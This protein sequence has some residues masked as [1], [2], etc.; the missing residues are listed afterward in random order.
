MVLDF[1]CIVYDCESSLSLLWRLIIHIAFRVMMMKLR[2]QRIISRRW[3]TEMAITTVLTT[4]FIDYTDTRKLLRFIWDKEQEFI[5]DCTARFLWQSCT[6]RA[7]KVFIRNSLYKHAQDKYS[8]VDKTINR[9]TDISNTVTKATAATAIEQKSPSEAA[10][11][12]GLC[13]CSTTFTD[14]SLKIYLQKCFN[15]T[16]IFARIYASKL[17]TIIIHS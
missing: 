1:P 15:K 4:D 13:G 6:L 2:Q 9:Q 3:K 16:D 5:E 11:P 10:W 12:S 14:I 17:C 8:W 7:F